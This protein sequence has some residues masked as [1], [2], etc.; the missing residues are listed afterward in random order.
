MI[1]PGAQQAAVGVPAL[2]HAVAVGTRSIFG[3]AAS[4]TVIIGRS[5][6]AR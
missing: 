4:A 1:H 3:L 5:A 6:V 2:M